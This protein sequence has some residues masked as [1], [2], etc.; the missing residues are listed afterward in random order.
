MSMKIQKYP[1]GAIRLCILS[2][3]G[4][5]TIS[6]SHNNLKQEAMATSRTIGSTEVNLSNETQKCAGEGDKAP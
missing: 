5:K 4:Q 3:L 6:E 1:L 2:P